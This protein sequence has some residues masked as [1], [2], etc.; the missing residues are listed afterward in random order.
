MV[1]NT[2]FCSLILISKQLIVKFRKFACRLLCGGEG[3]EVSTHSGCRA[4]LCVKSLGGASLPGVV[5]DVV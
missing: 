1:S 4:R 2:Q 3:G 5:G